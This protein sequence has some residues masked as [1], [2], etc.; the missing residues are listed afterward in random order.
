MEHFKKL[1]DRIFTSL[2]ICIRFQPFSYKFSYHYLKLGWRNISVLLFQKIK[3]MIRVRIIRTILKYTLNTDFNFDKLFPSTHS[4]TNSFVFP[5]KYVVLRSA[6]MVSCKLREKWHVLRKEKIFFICPTPLPP[7]QVRFKQFPIPGPKDWT[8]PGNCSG[9]GWGGDGN[10]SN[11]TIHYY[12]LL[13]R[14]RA[15]PPNIIQKLQSNFKFQRQRPS[16]VV[17][18]YVAAFQYKVINSILWQLQSC[19]K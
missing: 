10:R 17:E 2:N 14:E 9:R 12:P 16:I 7:E 5:S 15:E 4:P 6:A 1:L 3:S 13:I 19:V 8:C 11:W 18:S